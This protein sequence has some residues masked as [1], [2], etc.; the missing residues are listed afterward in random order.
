MRGAFQHHV[1]AEE[2]K[3]RGT[4][5]TRESFLAWRVKFDKDMAAKRAKEQEEK[6]KNI[7]SKEREEYKKFQVRPTGMT[8]P[9]SFWMP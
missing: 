4:P 6:L 7:T 3:T 5:V 9:L 8:G 2:V 1:E